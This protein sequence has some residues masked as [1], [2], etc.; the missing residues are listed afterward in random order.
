MD[1]R[2]E[3][4]VVLLEESG[5]QS[6]RSSGCQNHGCFCRNDKESPGRMLEEALDSNVPASVAEKRSQADFHKGC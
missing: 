6:W 4:K 5:V 2:N 1:E 3:S